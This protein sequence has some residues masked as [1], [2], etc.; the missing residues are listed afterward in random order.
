M[1][2]ILTRDSV[3]AG[4]DVDAPHRVEID[5]VDG[6]NV[7]DIVRKIVQTSYLPLIAGG[8][9]TWSVVSKRPIAVIAQQWKEPRMVSQIPEH[10]EGL[11]REDDAPR[12]HLNYHAQLDP[13]IVLEV[14][15]RL[16]RIGF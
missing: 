5:S 16:S 8:E 15:A 2:V 3:A 1:R 4:D 6:A 9:A 14:L 7:S 12:F 13:E 11:K 10:V